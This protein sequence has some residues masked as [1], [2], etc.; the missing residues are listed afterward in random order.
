MRVDLAV[1]V[2]ATRIE[3]L[4]LVPVA[5]ETP[6]PTPFEWLPDAEWQ[7]SRRGG[8]PSDGALPVE[9]VE[10]VATPKKTPWSARSHRGAFAVR[11]WVKVSAAGRA[12]RMIPLEVSDP[13]LLAYF[14]RATASWLFQPASVR[15][16][17]A[18][19]WNE[20]SA[21]GQIE[22]SVD[23]K[24]IAVLRRSL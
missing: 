1:E 10:T 21:S 16:A 8:A 23:I 13:I 2:D 17:P 22:Y 11:L 14:K 9:Q 5:P 6:L 7:E 3:R 15:G 24:Q 4:A 20:L 19:S 18:D 12:E